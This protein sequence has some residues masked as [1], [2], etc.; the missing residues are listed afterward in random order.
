MLSCW[1]RKAKSRP[2]FI[3]IIEI[4]L[5]H[6]DPKPFLA[7][8]FYSKSKSEQNSASAVDAS[9]RDTLLPQEQ[10]TGDDESDYNSDDSDEQLSKDDI[11]VQ[12]FPLSAIQ[13]YDENGEN[14]TDKKQCVG[15][16][17][18]AQ[19]E[20]KDTYELQRE[21]HSDKISMLSGLHPMD[22]NNVSSENLSESNRQSKSVSVSSTSSSTTA[23]SVHK[24][25]NFDQTN[26]LMGFDRFDM[27][28]TRKEANNHNVINGHL[29][30]TS[31]V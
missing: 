30:N 20:E 10:S 22:N 11:N 29:I 24:A 14:Q 7:V 18:G 28:N 27:I 9:A 13:I 19:G 16:D 26:E 25:A 15:D 23:A 31:M 2:T 3:K 12:F 1:S 21:H 4:L 6:V 5:N 8:S 17:D